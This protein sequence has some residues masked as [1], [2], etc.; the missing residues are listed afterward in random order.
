MTILTL[1]GYCLVHVHFNFHRGLVRAHFVEERCSNSK[2]QIIQ[3]FASVSG[4]SASDV[5]PA[6]VPGVSP[7][8]VR[9]QSGVSRGQSGVSPGSV[10]GPGLVRGQSGVRP[11]SVRGQSGV[12]PGP[13]LIQG[14]GHEAPAPYPSNSNCAVFHL[15]FWQFGI[16]LWIT[17]NRMLAVLSW[18]N[19]LGHSTVPD[20]RFVPEL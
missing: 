16:A 11:G 15:T 7:G 5:L 19:D 18:W 8:S 4:R 1:V 17:N 9:G 20:G 2:T 12:S 3:Q 14:R 13:E 6:S 10:W